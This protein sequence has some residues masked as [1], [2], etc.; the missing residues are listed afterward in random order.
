MAGVVLGHYVLH[1]H[2]TVT[3]LPLPIIRQLVAGLQRIE[4]LVLEDT[5]KAVAEPMDAVVVIEGVLLLALAKVG[6]D[7]VSLVQYLVSSDLCYD[8]LHGTV[9][10]TRPTKVVTLAVRG[11]YVAVEIG[12]GATD[13]VGELVAIGLYELAFVIFVL[14]LCESS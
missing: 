8:C 11:G 14:E 5:H 7:S 12:G 1:E 9:V 13:D 2:P 4:Q 6:A 10:V 3:G